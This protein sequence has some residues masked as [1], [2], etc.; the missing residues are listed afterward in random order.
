MRSFAAL[1]ALPAWGQVLYSQNFDVD[2]TANWT[3][4]VAGSDGLAD[5]FYDY[6]ASAGIPAAPNSG[7]TTRG[8]K[9][10][11]NLTAAT[12]GGGS[13]SPNGQTF[14]GDYKVT[15]DLW[16]NYLGADST[17]GGTG[18]NPIG[19]TSGSTMLSTYGILTSGTF[20]NRARRR[21]RTVLR[22]HGRRQQQRLP[23]LLGR[24]GDQLPVSASD[25]HPARPGELGQ[26]NAA[27]AHRFPRHVSRGTRQIIRRASRRPQDSFTSI[28]FRP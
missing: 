14:T 1:S 24:A 10:Q 15:F 3:Y 21:R 23:H 4:T 22:Q 11:A 20:A 2:D 27:A 13:A 7:G 26:S 19:T 5:Y 9:L 17:T 28:H 6:G 8:M 12:F 18:I 25:R 16:S